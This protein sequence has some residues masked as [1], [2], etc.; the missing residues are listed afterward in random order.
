MQETPIGVFQKLTNNVIHI[1]HWLQTHYNLRW[2]DVAKLLV[3]ILLVGF[4]HLMVIQNMEWSS[5]FAHS[6][7]ANGFCVGHEDMNIHGLCFVVNASLAALMY[8]IASP[9]APVRLS[10]PAA[11]P[12]RKNA[13]SLLGHAVGHLFLALMEH[14]EVGADQTF[15]IF[16][17]GNYSV[18]HSTS[19]VVAF[20]VLLGVWYGFKR[21]ARFRSTGVA[22]LLALIHNTLQFF[23]FPSKFFFVHVL[24]SVLGDS[25][26]RGIW[27][28]SN[29]DLYYDLEAWLV[30]VPILLMTFT[31]SL[32]CDAFLLPYGGH[33][34][35]D[36]V[37]PVGFFVYYAIVIL[38]GEGR[39]VPK[40]D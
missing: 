25:A 34:W 10:A 2:G 19:Q 31:E 28:R 17:G 11:A 13:T 22:V 20:T 1:H 26:V 18:L 33:L 23:I 39:F 16:R 8:Y 27:F 38:S 40:C 35:F 12:I 7:Q 6:Y 32:G 15:E 4:I 37:V 24:I 21:D 9:R 14:Y 30:D 36:M 5:P 3:L 29:K